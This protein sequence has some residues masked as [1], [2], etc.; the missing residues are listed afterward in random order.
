MRK[1]TRLKY[2]VVVFFCCL[3]LNGIAQNTEMNEEDPCYQIVVP[4][5][6]T[7]EGDGLERFFSI[8]TYC[9]LQQFEFSLYNRWGQKIFETD[10]QYFEWDGFNEKT[11]QLYEEGSYFYICNYGLTKEEESR[12]IQGSLLILR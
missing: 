6:F 3:F 9:K 1:R 11:N 12:T 7:P 10:D 5:V 4:N 2:Q 8:A